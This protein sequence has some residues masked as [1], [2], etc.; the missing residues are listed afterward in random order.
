MVHV[1]RVT[2]EFVIYSL[3]EPPSCSLD[4]HHLFTPWRV[5]GYL[6]TISYQSK[7]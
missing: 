1:V 3:F 2:R 7:H 5:T 6:I 4:T